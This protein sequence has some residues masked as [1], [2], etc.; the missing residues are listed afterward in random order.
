[1][2]SSAIWCQPSARRIPAEAQPRLGVLPIHA[3]ILIY[4][5]G[6]TEEEAL[7]D[8]D[9]NLLQL[10]KRCKDKNIKLNKEKI[11]LRSKEVPFMGHMIT[12]EG[13]KADPEK[14]RAVQEMPT[15][16]DVAGIQRFIGFTNNLSKFLPRLSDVCAPLCQLTAQDVEWFWTDIHDRAVS[17]VKSCYSSPSSKVF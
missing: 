11:K 14:I 2:V 1:M 4:G 13:L 3:A 8:H 17:Q 15:P 6:T 7:Q 16:T 9:K 5:A 10:M 12:S